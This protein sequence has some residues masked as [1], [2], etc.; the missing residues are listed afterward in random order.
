MTPAAKKAKAMISQRTPHTART[1]VDRQR[2]AYV[3][4]GNTMGGGVTL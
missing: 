2:V 3:T 1:F 4:E